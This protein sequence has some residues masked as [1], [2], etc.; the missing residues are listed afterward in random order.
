MVAPA[1]EP[2]SAAT[3]GSVGRE[4]A[5]QIAP[6]C[7]STSAAYKMAGAAL[8][9]GDR[10]IRAVQRQRGRRIIRAQIG[11]TSRLLARKS[12]SIYPPHGRLRLNREPAG[13]CF[14]HVA[15]VHIL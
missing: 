4:T 14:A 7:G 8:T 1:G 3:P 6:S 5:G 11:R 13:W 2:R 12:K 15:Y 10:M 9:K